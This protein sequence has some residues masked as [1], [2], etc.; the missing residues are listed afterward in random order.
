VSRDALATVL[1]ALL[2]AVVLAF[3]AAS[4]CTLIH[5]E[6]RWHATKGPR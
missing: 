4:S 3:S 6:D 5:R 1:G 2:L